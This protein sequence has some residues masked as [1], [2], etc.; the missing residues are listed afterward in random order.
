MKP[1]PRLFTVA[2]LSTLL[3]TG[4][5]NAIAFD[6]P[7]GGPMGWHKGCAINGQMGGWGNPYTL[8][9]VYQLPDLT[10]EQRK[11]VD[12]LRDKIRAQR[13]Q[14]RLDRR[15]LQDALRDKVPVEQ[16][17]PLAEKQGQHLTAMILLRAE[18]RAALEQILTKEQ[19]AQLEKDGRG[20]PRHFFR[21]HGEDSDY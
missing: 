13:D 18:T 4:A 9:R 11:E 1:T 3:T 20:E 10:V 5:G 8:R 7:M 14:W 16:L 17:K 2:L 15:A 21:H 19:R 12:A 6:G